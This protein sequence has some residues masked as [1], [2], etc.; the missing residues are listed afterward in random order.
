MPPAQTGKAGDQ[1][2]GD[3]PAT[4]PDE[5][6]HR[7]WEHCGQL[8]CSVPM[9]RYSFK[10]IEREFPHHVDMQVPL[11]GLGKKLDTMYAW[12]KMRGIQAMHGRGR[13]TDN[14]RDIIRWCF[15][16]PALATEFATEFR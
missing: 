7:P 3:N 10:A 11:G 4:P 6:K 14:G 8:C 12:H 2:S 1:P 9:S 15:D 13:R 5:A 16:D